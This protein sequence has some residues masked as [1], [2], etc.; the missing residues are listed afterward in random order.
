MKPTVR[1]QIMIPPMNKRRCASKQADLLHS[2]IMFIEERV[3][4]SVLRLHRS[5]LKFLMKE[6]PMEQDR[7]TI[8]FSINT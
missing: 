4:V 5:L 3:I 7:C 2:S 1:T 8:Y 6:A